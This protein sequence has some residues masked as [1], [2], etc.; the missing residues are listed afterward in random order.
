M[1]QPNL[2]RVQSAIND[3]AARLEDLAA[4]GVPG[5]G[6]L[7]TLLDALKSQVG[8]SFDPRALIP[9]LVAAL[10]ADRAAATDPVARA[11]LGVIASALGKLAPAPAPSP[12]P[13]GS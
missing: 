13:V 8:T 4:A 11:I 10:E 1:D 3:L 6:S 9:L 7:R 12:T 2:D 5:L